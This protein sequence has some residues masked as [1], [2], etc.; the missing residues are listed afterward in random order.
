MTEW[1]EALDLIRRHRYLD[2]IPVLWLSVAACEN[3]D[4][5]FSALLVT[6][7]VLIEIGNLDAA[8]KVA[9]RSGAIFPG[10]SEPY[11]L[12]AKC[13]LELGR[14]SFALT[15]L[16]DGFR[17]KPTREWARS[18]WR[19][20]GDLYAVRLYSEILLAL[21][22]NYETIEATSVSLRDFK[23]DPNLVGSLRKAIKAEAW[24]RRLKS[25]VETA[26]KTPSSER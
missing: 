12:A 6:S 23:E 24:Q 21:G 25:A 14:T 19:L 11:Y 3:S 26:S 9:E 16:I 5:E 10:A 22:W 7:Q 2:A 20:S 15:V 17:R 1:K 8:I 18:P 4:D 13:Y